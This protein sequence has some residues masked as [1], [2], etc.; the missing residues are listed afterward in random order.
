MRLPCAG[1]QIWHRSQRYLRN[2][3]VRRAKSLRVVPMRLMR[4]ASMILVLR[5]LWNNPRFSHG[6]G[7]CPANALCAR[8]PPDLRR[9]ACG[10]R[11]AFIS[12]MIAAQ[13]ISTSAC[14]RKDF[15]LPQA[16]S[17]NASISWATCSGWS[18][19]SMWPASCTTAVLQV[20]TW[21]RRW[22]YSVSYTHLTLPTICSV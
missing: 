14:G 13:A 1:V 3:C 16:A 8:P 15:K 11:V 7:R 19:C 22:W 20:R 6:T 12:K 10:L 21:V 18:W 9:P 2:S 17:K 4:S 5:V